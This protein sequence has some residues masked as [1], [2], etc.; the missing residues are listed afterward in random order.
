MSRSNAPGSRR[1]TA[2]A[3]LPPPSSTGWEVVSPPVH[4]FFITRYNTPRGLRV[5][6]SRTLISQRM[7]LC[8]KDH[9]PKIQH[10]VRRE[11]Q[12]EILQ[13]LREE[14]AR[15]QIRLLLR[16]DVLQR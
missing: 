11:D 4:E 14:V 6:S 10:A 2:A 5:R 1:W 3:R 12:I 13:R 8:R 7:R 9:A 15:H 16:D